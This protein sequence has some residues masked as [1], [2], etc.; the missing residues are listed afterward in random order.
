MS[1][2]SPN[3]RKADS[4]LPETPWYQRLNLLNTTLLIF[5]LAVVFSGTQIEGNER[6]LDVWQNLGRFLADFFPP[7]L[8]VVGQTGAALLETVEIA[9]LAT[10]FAIG[11]SL[12]IGLGAAQ[13]IAPKWLVVTM[14]MLLNVIR[15]IPS[16]IWAVIAVAAMGA[17]ALAGVVA[18]TLY[19]IGYLGKFFSEAFESVDMKVARSLRGIG[20]DPLQAFQYGI[21]PHAKPL[22]WS[23]SIWM[24][25]YNIRSA[26]II[27]YVGAGGLGLQLHAYQE[28]HQWDRFATVLICILCVVTLLDLLSERI[29]RRITRRGSPNRPISE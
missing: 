14:R 17:N 10:F 21:W 29:R 8:S 6:D 11:L 20:A 28:F 15:T 9:I 16:L 1:P 7:D 18:L 2:E 24:L 5:L 12:V 27:G 4:R 23:H 25:E 3:S 26:S 13:T 19:S 22:I